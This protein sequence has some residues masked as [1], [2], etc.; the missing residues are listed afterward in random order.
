MKKSL[1]AAL[2]FAA[3]T[4]TACGGGASNQPEATV[5]PVSTPDL[6]EITTPGDLP[7][8][9]LTLGVSISTLSNPFFIEIEDGIRFAAERNGINVNILG[10]SDNSATQSNDIDDLLQMG[11]DAILVNPVD[12]TAIAS[13]IEY[14]N[15]SHGVP[16]ITIDRSADSGDVITFIASNNVEGGEQAANLIV[17][18]VGEGAKVIELEGIPGSSAANE[19][20]LGFNNVA[21]SQLDVVARQTAN[22]NRSEGLNVM[23]NL[24]QANP[25]IVAVFAHN[26]EMALGAIEALRGFGILDQVIVVGFDGTDD[27]IEAIN[28]GEMTA[29]VAQQPFEMGVLAVE[30]AIRSLEGDFVDPKIDSPL[31]LI[32]Q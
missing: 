11:V 1:I 6:P 15:G 26:D 31:T 17:E 7:S 14:I 4:L 30:A 5:P 25:D 13:T 29:T 22:F 21:N 19:R 9:D 27:A 12:S 18:L 16:V 2:S 24:L 20:G 28:A 8:R 3:M 23:E 10:A 32:M